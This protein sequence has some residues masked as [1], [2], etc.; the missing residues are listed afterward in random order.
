MLK[1]KTPKKVKETDVFDFCCRQIRKCG[2]T[3]EN[4]ILSYVLQDTWY[5]RVNIETVSGNTNKLDYIV[6]KC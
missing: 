1:T 6:S 2:T 4:Y 5:G 3:K